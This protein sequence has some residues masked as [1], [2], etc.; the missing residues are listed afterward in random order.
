MYDALTDAAENIREK[1]EFMVRVGHGTEAQ[2]NRCRS[3]AGQLAGS[4]Y[5][6]VQDPD[7]VGTDALRA[8]WE[9]YMQQDSGNFSS[10]PQPVA[11]A[12]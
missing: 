4:V 11:H 7:G 6:F 12:T 9:T 10:D 8:A 1:V 2:F 3:A 5:A